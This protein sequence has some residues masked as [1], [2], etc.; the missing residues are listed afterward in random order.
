MM[1]MS[2][3]NVPKGP[4]MEANAASARACMVAGMHVHS[5]DAVKSR[6]SLGTKMDSAGLI[7]SSTK[8]GS[9]C[10]CV[11]LGTPGNQAVQRASLLWQTDNFMPAKTESYSAATRP[12]S[13]SFGWVTSSRHEATLPSVVNVL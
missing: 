3:Q 4:M 12:A 1:D 11:F 13:K 8:L 5:I 2:H 10:T 7:S 6:N 9:N